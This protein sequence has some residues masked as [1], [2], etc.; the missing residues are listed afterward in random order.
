[1]MAVMYA[2]VP[3]E[4]H[5]QVVYHGLAGW[6]AGAPEEADG[7]G[8]SS[9]PPA[10]MTEP[11]FA[12]IFQAL[13]SSKHI[14]VAPELGDALVNTYFTYQ[15]FSHIRRSTFL[16]D[17]ALG[18]PLYSDF[19]L[20][21][22]YASA[23]RMVDGLEPEQRRAQADLFVRLARD[24]LAKEMQGPSRIPTVQGLLLL[25]GREV[26]EGNVSH[27]WNFAGLAFRML[28]DVSLMEVGVS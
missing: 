7:A 10:G 12:P 17:M 3:F 21:A 19:L 15:V 6:S 9:N 28:Q 27:G 22:I 1:M 18:G 26:S 25:S 20:M 24:Y 2:C 11:A 4:A 5:R 8:P 23:T 14:S 13:A 16:R